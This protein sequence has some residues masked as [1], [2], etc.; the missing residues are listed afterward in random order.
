MT[1]NPDFLPFAL[2][3]IGPEEIA[4]VVDTLQSGWL[5][6]GP[7]TNRFE[8][9]FAEFIGVPHAIAVNS[10]TA[11]LHLSLEAIGLSEGD[12]VITT[13]YTFTASAEVIRYLGA[14]PLFADIDP[15]TMNI[16]P[17]NIAE[18]TAKAS[19]EGKR[20]KAILPVHFAGHACDMDAIRK[21]A[22]E[23]GLEIVGDAAHAF[24]TSYRGNWIG[25][26][27]DLAAFSFYVTK[28]LATGEG[29][30]VTTSNEEYAKRVRTMRLHGIS[31]DIWDRY[32][33]VKPNWY[34]EVVAPGFKYNLTDLAASIGIHQLRKGKAFRKRRAEI[35]EKYS[36]ALR[37]LPLL[38][39]PES[40]DE[41]VPSWHLFVIRLCLDRLDIDRDRFIELMS[42]RGIGTSVHFIPLHLHPYWRDKY[43]FRPEDFPV[44]LDTYRRC[45]SLPIYTRMTDADVSR[46]VDAVKEI[47]TKYSR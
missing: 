45:V 29:G 35:A 34:Y 14:H 8:K 47:L 46:V 38:L 41:C 42:E 26:V 5:T 23:N 9:D 10:G 12:A 31:R 3:D 2:P 6:T 30:M 25:A 22:V 32:S 16:A 33:S 13:P 21:I 27:E 15:V 28:P 37:G 39:P 17:E 40:S 20:V 11:A 36:E 43:G 19:F 7:K 24:P 1:D 18:V 4:E 44:A